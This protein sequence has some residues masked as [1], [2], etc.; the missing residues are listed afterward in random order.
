[1]FLH[2]FFC[3]KHVL[4]EK[5]KNVNLSLHNIGRYWY[6]KLWYEYNKLIHDKIEF[7]SWF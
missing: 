7:Q 5:G 6:L 3:R 1:M 4:E 2:C